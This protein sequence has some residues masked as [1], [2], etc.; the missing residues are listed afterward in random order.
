MGQQTSD[1][2]PLPKTWYFKS[3]SAILASIYLKLAVL[4]AAILKSVVLHI[5]N[6]NRNVAILVKMRGLKMS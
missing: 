4:G 6:C 5:S 1:S 2:M 3:F